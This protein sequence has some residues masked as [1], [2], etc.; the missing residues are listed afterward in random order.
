MKRLAA[1]AL[2]LGGCLDGAVED[3]GDGPKASWDRPTLQTPDEPDPVPAEPSEVT[4]DFCDDNAYANV[5]WQ[6]YYSPHFQLNYLPNTAAATDRLAIAARLEN[7]YTEIR[8]NLGVTTQPIFTVNLSPSRTAATQH[9]RGFGVA[10]PNLNRYDVIYTGTYDSF[11]VV[12]PGSLMT[13]MLDYQVDSQNRSRLSILTT[14]L[15]EYLDQSGRDMHAA[16]ALQLEAGIESRVRIAELDN[17]DVNGRNPGRAG[18]LVQFLIDRY[19][20]AEFNDIYRAATVSWNG[21]CM[22]NP[23]YGCV[24]TPEQVTAMLG[25][26]LSTHVQEDWATVQPLWQEA[27]EEALTDYVIGMAPTATEQIENIVRLMD[28]AIT[29]KDA[30]MYRS[31]LEGFYCEY[32][33]EALRQQISERAVAAFGSTTSKVIAIF[34][35]GTKNFSSA[36]ALVQ[37]IDEGGST[38]FQ[39]LM[40]EHVPDGWRV[41]YGPDWY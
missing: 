29:T 31:T 17:R 14:G 25:G 34:D 32:G 18:S 26:L 5:T 35:T 15:A 3:T 1:L 36:Q 21:T 33:G 2:L 9:G 8:A 13:W 40:F 38:T 27:V 10:W 39:T 41:S 6:T 28:K 24:T 4:T 19:G 37:R 23:T 30:A 22:A 11:E 12:R 20:I 7:A 16:Y